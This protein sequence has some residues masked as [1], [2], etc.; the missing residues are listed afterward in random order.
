MS[1]IAVQARHAIGCTSAA[2]IPRYCNRLRTYRGTLQTLHGS[3]IP[4]PSRVSLLLS[5][6]PSRFPFCID[7]PRFVPI[8][9]HRSLCYRAVRDQTGLLFSRLVDSVLSVA[10]DCQRA[11]LSFRMFAQ[12]GRLRR[13]GSRGILVRERGPVYRRARNKRKNEH[14]SHRSSFFPFFRIIDREERPRTRRKYSGFGRSSSE[15]FARNY[16]Y[17]Y[18]IPLESRFTPGGG[19]G[20]R[21]WSDRN[22]FVSPCFSGV[23]FH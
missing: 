20:G 16:I 9:V 1:P 14:G 3:S 2:S 19:G 5:L 4:I 7:V 21:A 8:P 6:F 10:K 13:L 23:R 22:E 12:V 11:I 15:H 18:L 17:V